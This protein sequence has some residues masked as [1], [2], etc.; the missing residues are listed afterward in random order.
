[1]SSSFTSDLSAE[2]KQGFKTHSKAF[3][4][5]IG[6]IVGSIFNSFTNNEASLSSKINKILEELSE[7]EQ[8]KFNQFF[9]VILKLV[10]YAYKERF[11]ADQL[12]SELL[13][14]GNNIFL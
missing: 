1:M 6:L 2:I 13:E 4:S 5:K 3:G 8:A 10:T 9:N 11:T 7:T 12:E 14:I